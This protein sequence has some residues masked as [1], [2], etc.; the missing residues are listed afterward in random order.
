MITVRPLHPD[1]SI[2]ELTDLLHRA[3][4]GL[5]ARGL[6]YLATHQDAD[7]T[8]ARIGDG[9]A[10]VA[11]DDNGAIVGTITWHRPGMKTGVEWY[12]R[13][14]VAHFG[15]FAVDPSERGAG[16]GRALLS[17]V[18]ARAHAAGARELACDTAEPATDLIEMYVRWGYRV[19]G[20]VD[21]RP[22]VNYPSV[23]LSKALPD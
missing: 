16:I 21:Y 12:D 10:L 20:T 19:V 13:P 14:G 11:I 8:R 6:R 15:Q 23:T 7:T 4:A 9:E 17:E 3:Y 18:E 22:V 1:D 2:D 5:A